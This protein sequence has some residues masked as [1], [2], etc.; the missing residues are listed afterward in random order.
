M[1]LTY[2]RDKV[3]YSTWREVV[4]WIGMVPLIL[5]GFIVGSDYFNRTFE[6]IQSRGQR[7]ALRK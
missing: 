5:C 6:D 4:M 7:T 2:W 1:N 3:P